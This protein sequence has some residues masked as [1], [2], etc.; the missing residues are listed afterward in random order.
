VRA[1]RAAGAAVV[2]AFTPA[3]PPSGAVV[4]AFTPARAI[5]SGLGLCAV[6]CALALGACE[7][8]TRN[9]ASLLL[10]RLERIDDEGPV[11]RRRAALEAVRR[12][13]LGEAEVVAVRDACVRAHDALLTAE[14]QQREARDLLERA[15]A[16]GRL[17]AEVAA[18]IERRIGASTTGI[19]RARALFPPC[20]EGMRALSLRYRSRASGPR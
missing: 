8:R 19:E 13:G 11:P 15:E 9:E 1:V 6:I 10:D 2:P 3:R 20:H 4:P 17:G 14:E 12:L 16:S 7:N 5:S 18:D